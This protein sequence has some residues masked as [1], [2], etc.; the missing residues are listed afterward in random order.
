VSTQ[1]QSVI[2][3]RLIQALIRAF[4]GDFKGIINLQRPV[5][6]KC[7][8]LITEGNK[9]APRPYGLSIALGIKSRI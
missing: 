9:I 2:T 1:A 5:L 7:S 8:L 6:R 3:I 4:H